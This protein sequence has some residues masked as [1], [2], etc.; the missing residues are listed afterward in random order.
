[1]SFANLFV[2]PIFA[3]TSQESMNTLR[4]G[5]RTGGRPFY[6]QKSQKDGWP[7]LVWPLLWVFYESRILE[8]SISGR[9][10]YRSRFPTVRVL[11][12]FFGWWNAFSWKT[13]PVEVA[14]SPSFLI[15]NAII[16]KLHQKTKYV[17]MHSM[18]LP[19]MR[20]DGELQKGGKISVD[21]FHP[22]Y[23]LLYCLWYTSD[24][25]FYMWYVMCPIFNCR[26]VSY[27]WYTVHTLS[28]EITNIWI[29]YILNCGYWIIIKNILKIGHFFF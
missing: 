1:M 8:F 24:R 5:Q 11:L 15:V 7:P 17:S 3:R 22:E 20:Y 26:V 12:P 2:I 4:K 21:T 10:L 9:N 27:W 13:R 6:R 18:W 16:L 28:G 29:R 19:V 25:V 14:S 23:I